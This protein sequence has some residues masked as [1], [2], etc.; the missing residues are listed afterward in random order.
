MTSTVASSNFVRKCITVSQQRYLSRKMPRFPFI[1]VRRGI[2][3]MQINISQVNVMRDDVSG[4]RQVHSS[5][6]L[7]ANP[8][9]SAVISESI[10]WQSFQF[11]SQLDGIVALMFATL[12]MLS[13]N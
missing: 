13:A 1:F 3:R 5:R 8:L 9:Y 4:Y 12:L 10:N 6:E 7:Q 2:K 11:D